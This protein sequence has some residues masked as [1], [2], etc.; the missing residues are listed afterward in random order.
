MILIINKDKANRIR[1]VRNNSMRTRK[2]Q[3]SAMIELLRALR[4]EISIDYD[5]ENSCST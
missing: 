3:W 2:M 1:K 4:L 5:K